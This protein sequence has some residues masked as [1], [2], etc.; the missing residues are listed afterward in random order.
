MAEYS[1]DH[2]WS[3]DPNEAEIVRPYAAKPKATGGIIDTSFD[4]SKASAWIGGH[5]IQ[6]IMT[7]DEGIAA[8]ASPLDTIRPL[9][10][11]HK[12]NFDKVANDKTSSDY[13]DFVAYLQKAIAEG[14]GVENLEIVLPSAIESGTVQGTITLGGLCDLCLA[15]LPE[16]GPCRCIK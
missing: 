9:D 13:M 8:R 10:D 6:G 4:P 2:R 5:K 15:L 14:M 1:P 7:R 12:F 11:G 16:D 3:G